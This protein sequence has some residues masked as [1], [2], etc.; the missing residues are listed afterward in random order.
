VTR[1]R[2]CG[3]RDSES[4]Y[5]RLPE[6]MLGYPIE[7]F[8]V[9]PAREWNGP[10]LRAPQP[11]TVEHENEEGEREEVTHLL[12]G[13]GNAYYPT[14]PSFLEE[15]KLQGVSKKIPI[16]SIPWERLEPGKSQVFLIHPRAIPRFDYR[17][18]GEC[19]MDVLER[20]VENVGSWLTP[21]MRKRFSG[22]IE[23]IKSDI[24]EK[25]RRVPDD[26]R[27]LG[28][29]WPLSYLV[30]NHK[31]QVYEEARQIPS[32]VREDPLVDPKVIRG[33]EKA[34]IA[35]WGEGEQHVLTYTIDR[36]RNWEEPSWQAGIF[37]H[38]PLYQIDY[39]TDTGTV[40]EGVKEEM[41]VDEKDWDLQVCEE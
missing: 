7:Y 6:S 31:H 27:C 29:L 23:R 19:P 34:M 16:R 39:V 32:Q 40:P 38:F 9:V 4:A 35:L 21:K 36:P 5:A 15:A 2:G 18:D 41:R 1:E 28:D 37:F 33:D 24:R 22:R 10:Q 30:N 8:Y 13:V 12:L 11:V 20:K 14:V 25:V 26:H 3:T 17:A